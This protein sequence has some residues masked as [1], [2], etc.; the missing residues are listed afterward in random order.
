MDNAE[1]CSWQ[2]MLC[3]LCMLLGLGAAITGVS[4]AVIAIINAT[5]TEDEKYALCD[6]STDFDFSNTQFCS[7]STDI[8]CFNDVYVANIEIDNDDELKIYD[9]NDE[10]IGN[11]YKAGHDG[12]VS[13][14]KPSCFKINEDGDEIFIGV[15][16]KE[17]K[18]LVKTYK[19]NKCDKS[20]EYYTYSVNVAAIEYEIYDDNDNLIVKS[21]SNYWG[22]GVSNRP[23]ITL[24]DNYGDIV[25][26]IYK[27]IKEFDADVW[28]V[29]IVDTELPNWLLLSFVYIENI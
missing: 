12:I 25:G 23:N 8:I 7:N 26:M 20:D 3:A 18:Q 10:Y 14:K 11:C 17:K 16:E 27:N 9:S 19:F 2:S 28:R 1:V 15:Y 22:V 21:D 13:D 6:D 4:F 29:V 24:I 5:K